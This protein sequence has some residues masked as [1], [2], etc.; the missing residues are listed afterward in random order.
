MLKNEAKLFQSVAGWL[1]V[2]VLYELL[3]KKDLIFPQSGTSEVELA[4]VVTVECG[5]FN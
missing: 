1:S 2:A 3:T 5:R 4:F